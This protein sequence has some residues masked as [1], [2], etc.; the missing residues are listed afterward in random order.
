MSAA[1]I[2]ETLR[3]EGVTIRRVG[4]TL[5]LKP[6]TGTVPADLIELARA[7][8]PELLAALPDPAEQRA[9]LL[10]AAQREGIDRAVVDALDDA[11][12]EGIEH[13]SDTQLRVA[14]RW[15]RDDPC[16]LWRQSITPPTTK[17]PTS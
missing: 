5:K 13:W 6:K 9:R 4:E 7:H 1:R 2:L 17:R 12:L 10:L 3:K 15:H 8:K 14:A 11:D 16:A